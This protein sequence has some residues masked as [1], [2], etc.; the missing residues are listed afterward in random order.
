[1]NLGSDLV[2]ALNHHWY[3]A[4]L[5]PQASYFEACGVQRFHSQKFCAWDQFCIRK[6]S[7]TLFHIWFF[8]CHFTLILKEN[9]SMWVTSGFLSGSHFSLWPTFNP[10]AAGDY[11][12]DVCRRR[13]NFRWTGIGRQWAEIVVRLGFSMCQSVIESHSCRQ[14]SNQIAQEHLANQTT[15]AISVATLTLIARV[16]IWDDIISQLIH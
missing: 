14:D 16:H 10:A 9:F 1:M 12:M 2:K 4:S 15:A 11:K 3:E 8:P 7:M 6:E 5:L 13:L